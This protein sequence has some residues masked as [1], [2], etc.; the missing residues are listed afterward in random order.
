VADEHTVQIQSVLPHL[1][2]SVI[3]VPRLWRRALLPRVLRARTR[4][5]GYAGGCRRACFY[6]SRA[7]THVQEADVCR[8]PGIPAPARSAAT[9]PGG[10]CGHHRPR[11]PSRAVSAPPSAARPQVPTEV[12]SVGEP[13][14]ADERRSERVSRTLSSSFEHAVCHRPRGVHA[15][16]TCTTS[17]S[18]CEGLPPPWE[19]RTALALRTVAAR[20]SAVLEVCR[21]RV[22][23]GCATAPNDR[24]VG[25]LCRPDPVVGRREVGSARRNHS[26]RRAT[27]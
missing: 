7:R 4:Y 26:P 1:L 5:D 13:V 8:D 10:P 18:A 14:A 3:V 20:V 16:P 23:A 17:R 27:P 11:C 19:C 2:Y 25:S 15:M 6:V 21:F 22:T 12:A 9:C 24:T